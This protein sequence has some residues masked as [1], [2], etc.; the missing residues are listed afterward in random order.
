MHWLAQVT[1]TR[2]LT[3]RQVLQSISDQVSFRGGDYLPLLLVFTAGLAAFLLYLGWRQRDRSDGASRMFRQVAADLS[4]RRRDRRLLTQIA[5]QQALPTPMTLLLSP[6]T[7]RRHG[8]RYADQFPRRRQARLLHRLA[9]LR[10][11]AFPS[12]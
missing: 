10:R 8:Q 5:R 4:L 7:L 1:D 3:P 11:R 6:L 9:R 12:N 2:Q